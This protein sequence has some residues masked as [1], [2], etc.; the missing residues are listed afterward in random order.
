MCTIN[1]LNLRKTPA[2]RG[3][4]LESQRQGMLDQKS[5]EQFFKTQGQQ[6]APCITF[7]SNHKNFKIYQEA[8][9]RKLRFACAPSLKF[10]ALVLRLTARN[11]GLNLVRSRVLHIAAIVGGSRLA[12]TSIVI[13][14][15]GS[16]HYIYAQ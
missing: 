15:I 7:Y 13:W 10:L 14:V 1:L 8:V 2:S 6:W 12:P 4:I 9:P 5:A 11:R 3:V 16:N